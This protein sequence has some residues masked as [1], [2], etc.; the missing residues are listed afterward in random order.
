[1][2]QGEEYDEDLVAIVLYH[3]DKIPINPNTVIAGIQGKVN[4]IQTISFLLIQ[5][6]EKSVYVSPESKIKQGYICP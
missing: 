2:F 6:E 5:K 3:P 4:S 1:M